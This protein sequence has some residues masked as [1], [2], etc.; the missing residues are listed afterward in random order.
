MG[1]TIIS[2]STKTI[3]LSQI[4]S[5]A[6]L[7]KKLVLFDDPATGVEAKRALEISSRFSRALRI[8]NAEETQ[9][10]GRSSESSY[11]TLI[12]YFEKRN[13]LERLLEYRLA[14]DCFIVLPLIEEVNVKIALDFIDTNP[15]IRKCIPI[16]DIRAD[17][18]SELMSRASTLLFT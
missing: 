4:V 8:L 10:I 13:A 5:A 11:L 1:T 9:K 14:P 3:V 7:G 17:S 2:G 15:A 12:T 6:R 16:G 18:R